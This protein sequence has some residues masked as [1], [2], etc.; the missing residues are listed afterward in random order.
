MKRHNIAL[1]IFL[2]AASSFLFGFQ[3]KPIREYVQVVNTELLLR[4]FQKEEMIGGL[5]K[6][7]F[8]LYED[9]EKRDINGFFEVH[10][11]ISMN[12]SETKKKADR[13]FLLFYWAGAREGHVNESLRQFFDTIYRK[14]DRVVL[15][16][17]KRSFDIRSEEQRQELTSEFIR[18]CKLEAQELQLENRAALK[19]INLLTTDFKE[20]IKNMV[21]T[22]QALIQ[23]F[24][25]RYRMLL[26]ESKF[27]RLTP[28]QAALERMAVSLREIRADKWALVFF[29]KEQ[30]AVLDIAS[31]ITHLR[32]ME[33]LLTDKILDDL[34][35][36]LSRIDV[37]FK[38]IQA[39]REMHERLQTQFIQASTVFHLLRLNTDNT[40]LSSGADNTY[41]LVRFSDVFSN[42]DM[43][44]QQISRVT[45]GKAVDGDHPGKAFAKIASS[46]DIYYMLTFEPKKKDDPKRK[47][48]IQLNKPGKFRL[49]FG[50]R[51]EMEK[52]PELS[53]EKAILSPGS[54]ELNI[55]GFHPIPRG[56]ESM[57]FVSVSVTTTQKGDESPKPLLVQDVE[58]NGILQ[59]PL[60]F[61]EPGE[62]QVIIRV[63][64][65]LT[66]LQSLAEKR[67]E[68]DDPE[69][70]KTD[71][72]LA[73]E[74][75]EL[76]AIL[77]KAGR[78]A[79]K[80][81]KT[82]LTFYCR[83]EVWMYRYSPKAIGTMFDGYK[84]T[85]WLYDYQIVLQE[86][87]VRENRVLLQKNSKKM[88]QEN[89]ALETRFRSLYS[90]FMPVTMLALDRQKNYRYKLIDRKR[91]KGRETW[92]VKVTPV[93][94]DSEWPEGEAWIDKKDGSV[95]KIQ[96]DQESIRGMETVQEEANKRGLLL[97]LSDTH[98]YFHQRKGIRFP[99]RTL[100]VERL[101]ARPDVAALGSLPQVENSRTFFT[102]S[103]YRFFDVK[104]TVK[105]KEIE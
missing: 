72:S 84:R 52:L 22:P 104:A 24:A 80:L 63:T 55:K 89:A 31:F 29:P 42:W 3:E 74:S 91:L 53:I 9:G 73:M 45:G 62:W 54:L 67:I 57:G 58:T 43:L 56:D 19:E 12:A 76:F 33:K 51:L 1:I 81:K 4:V 94:E 102:Y 49:I 15:A 37:E 98:E 16:T 50:R 47:I 39:E 68:I 64:D 77:D 96:I 21:G 14:G 11:R 101:I 69:A 87:Q 79:E 8:Q 35:K 40:P 17:S 59:F 78:Y 46:E 93:A 26:M 27:K 70:I 88:N 85:A 66:G 95:L 105:E 65:L 86:G 13:L 61:P 32:F 48:E 38:S 103:D 2:S 90:F 97:R 28:D 60:A 44:L 41:N 36:E 6:E 23:N 82:G 10:H 20:M 100:I 99:S 71:P 34:E 25:N 92:H 30:V 75:G 18:Q 5:K 83:E 7:D